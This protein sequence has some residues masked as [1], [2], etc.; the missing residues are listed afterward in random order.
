MQPSDSLIPIG[1]GY[2]LPLPSAYLVAGA[3]S[4]PH[5][6]AGSMRVPHAHCA[7]ETGHRLSAKSGCFTRRNEGLPGFWAVL[8]KRAVVV[9]PVGCESLLAHGA[10]TAVAFRL[11]QAL[12]TQDE[13]CFVAEIPTAHLLAYLRID[14]RVAAKRRKARYRLGGLAPSRAGFARAG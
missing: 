1:L 12:G 5:S 9:D 11:H 7:S 10:E 14:V 3:C 8:F 4:V 2:G 6:A 13:D